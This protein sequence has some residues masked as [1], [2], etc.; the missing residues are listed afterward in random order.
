MKSFGI[1]ILVIGLSA[2]SVGQEKNFLNNKFALKPGKIELN[3]D[4]ST[5]PFICKPSLNSWYKRKTLQNEF[6]F[7]EF[8]PGILGEKQVFFHDE[9]MNFSSSMPVYRPNQ[10]CMMPIMEPDSTMNYHLL[11][12]KIDVSQ[13]KGNQLP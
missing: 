7:Q 11:V 12:K 1:I 5:A 13:R 9:P 8:S 3:T 10:N 4:Y 2:N 6:K